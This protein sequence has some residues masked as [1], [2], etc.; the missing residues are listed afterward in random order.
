MFT[1]LFI[2]TGDH[3]GRVARSVK[4]KVSAFLKDVPAEHIYSIN[5]AQSQGVDNT[6]DNP[7]MEYCVSVLI[8]LYDHSQPAQEAAKIAEQEAKA[9]TERSARIA[10]E[11]ETARALLYGYRQ[12]LALQKDSDGTW[13]IID[14]KDICLYNVDP[15]NVLTAVQHWLEEQ[16]Q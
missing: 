5:F 4:Q 9:Q 14:G 6:G 3:E 13:A 12:D 8:V 2:G 10:K 1:E 15:E 11:I 16:Q 7:F